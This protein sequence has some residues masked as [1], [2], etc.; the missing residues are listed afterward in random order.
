M[1]KYEVIVDGQQYEVEIVR[2]DGRH[3][4]LK[5]DGQEYE[6]EASNVSSVSVP[7]A[8]PASAAPTPEPKPRPQTAAA[9]PAAP[10]NV[11]AGDLQVRAPMPG[12]VLQVCVSVDQGV[13]RGDVL[14]RLEAMKMENDIESHVEGKVKEILVKKGDEVQEGEVLMVLEG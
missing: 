9:P 8:S 2:D 4:V 5:V 13:K 10:D 7:A 6:V 3:A 11:G 14:L 12:L 1:A